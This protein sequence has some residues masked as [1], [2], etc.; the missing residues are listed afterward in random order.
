MSTANAI[1]PEKRPRPEP[2][3]RPK[4][5]VVDA[6]PVP[7][8][9]PPKKLTKPA[10]LSSQREKAQPDPVARARRSRRKARRHAANLRER[11]KPVLEALSARWP[12]IFPADPAQVRPWAVGLF[13][14]LAA[15]HTEYSRVLLRTALDLVASS[16]AYQAALARGGPR[17]DLDGQPKGEV[18]PDHQAKAAEI[19]GKMRAGKT[20]S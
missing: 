16:E 7:M 10:K 9:P 4:P 14:Q 20:R 11:A 6:P 17:Y 8:A 2:R 12:A 3:A 5:A 15:Q 18:S 13:E 19:L 1:R